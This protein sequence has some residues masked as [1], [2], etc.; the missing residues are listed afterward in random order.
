MSKRFFSKIIIVALAVVLSACAVGKKYYELG[1]QLQDA[2]KYKEAMAYYKEALAK[3]PKNKTYQQALTELKK[4][5]ITKYITEAKAILNSSEPITLNKINKAKYKLARAE[6]IDPQA[7]DVIAL[8]NEIKV[9]ENKFLTEVKQIY[10]HAQQAIREN[11]WDKAYFLLSQLQSK[12]PNYEDSATLLTQC[13]REGAKFYLTQAQIFFDKE[14][15]KQAIF[16]LR[17][18]LAL[19]PQNRV[20]HKLLEQARHN[21]NKEYFLSRAREE[22]IAQNWDKA[23]ELYETALEYDPTDKDLKQ[24]LGQVKLKAGEYHIRKAKENIKSGWLLKAVDS[25]MMAQKYI[26]DKNDYKLNS[27]KQ[28]LAAR[29]KFI[30]DH[31]KSQEQYELAWYWYTKVKQI[32]PEYPKISSLIQEM[33]KHISKRVQKSIAVFDFR[34]PSNNRDAGVIIA[35]KLITFLFN[36]ASGDIKIMERENLN[37]I[38]EEMKLEQIGIVS[39]ET[40]KKVGQMYGIDIAIMGSVLLFKVESIMSKSKKTVRYQVGTKIQDNI[41]YLNWKA[42]HPKPTKQELAEAPPAKIVVPEYV[43]KQY[44][45]GEQKKVGF[46][47]ISFKIIDIATGE[48]IQVKTIKRKCIFEDETNA[49]IPEAHIKYDPLELPTNTEILQNLTLEVVAELGRE[50][51]KPL[52]NLEKKYFQEGENLLKRKQNLQA[53][54]KFIDALFDERLKSV[55]NSPIIKD[56][57][58]KVEQIFYMYQIPLGE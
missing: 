23:V 27:L 30:G 16:F 20:A 32:F 44:E 47:E 39:T 15:F 37:S 48:N 13:T 19:D 22:V 26:E 53:A 9:K 31:F 43:E 45:V 46:V 56:A 18:T 54:V 49:G 2:G 38:L 12:F 50:V 14:K 21:D 33:G 41:D 5:L 34:S 10:S 42:K 1:R 24:L 7:R 57:L 40:A 4:E 29:L 58:E 11:K 17:K 3:E 52:R 55:A 36:N 6:E 8:K 28:S 51:L 35:N 25:Y